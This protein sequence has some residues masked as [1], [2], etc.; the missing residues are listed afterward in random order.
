[1]FQILATICFFLSLFGI[2]FMIYRKIPI[3]LTLSPPKKQKEFIDFKKEFLNR[4]PFK[5]FSFNILLQKMLVRARILS[6][7][8]D[9]KTFNLLKK[10]R[11]KN[12]EKKKRAKEDDYWEK[13]KKE[14]KK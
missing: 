9:Y 1:M 13:I 4:L 6:L 5:N 14:I 12:N 10:I 8:I 7:K 11:E 3:L 2:A